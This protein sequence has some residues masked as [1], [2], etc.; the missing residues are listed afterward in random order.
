MC[1][2]QLTKKQTP[3]LIKHRGD[4]HFDG[5]EFDWFYNFSSLPISS[6]DTG[7][8]QPL[9]LDNAFL[10]FNGE[11]FNY[12]DFGGYRSDLHY[13][14]DL[15][16]KELFSNKFRQQYKKWDGFWSICYLD[17]DGVI[18]FTDPLGK[19]QLYY[20][21]IGICSEIK[22]LINNSLLMSIARYNTLNTNFN[23]VN[24]AMPGIFYRY[25]NGNSL[26]YRLPKTVSDY[27]GNGNDG[28]LYTMIDKSV[29]LRSITNYG[30]LGLLF[31][32]GLDSSIVAHHLV[33]N[34]IEFK[35]LSI[36]NNETGNAKRIAKQI[37][38]DLEFIDDKIS[39]SEYKKLILHYEYN[40][41]YGSLIPQ[42]LL[43]KKA[44]ELGLYTVLTG[45]GADELFSG[46][47]RA[48]EGD[49]QEYDVFSELPYYHHIRIDRVSMM[50][51]VEARNPFLSSDI[52]NY[53]LKTKYADRVGK[54]N[55]REIYKKHFDTSVKKKPLRYKGDKDKNLNLT[56]ETFMTEFNNYINTQNGK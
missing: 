24:R 53:A 32:G 28:D 35:A 26:A 1:G 8:T 41:D 10:F 31:S 34:N 17:K 50:H 3:N 14:K 46:Y 40:L 13:L 30:K 55:L 21:H 54:K 6:N 45:D 36:E 27:I 11:I 7:L 33:K 12:K 51:T 20:N 4:F 38:F 47:T 25:D 37:G 49:T 16:K 23:N 56:Q 43:F 42:Y 5:K 52:I 9:E 44:K 19:K 22:P 39:K 48:L 18:F 29:K 2:I 15:F